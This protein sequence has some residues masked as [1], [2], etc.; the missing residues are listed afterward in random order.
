VGMVYQWKW[1]TS[2]NGLPVGMVYQREW[3]K[4]QDQDQDKDQKGLIPTSSNGLRAGVVY[5]DKSWYTTSRN[6]I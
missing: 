3:I 4:T 2:G 5:I 1:H 6:G